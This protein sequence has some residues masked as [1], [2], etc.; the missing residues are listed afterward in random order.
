LLPD[1]FTKLDGTRITAKADWECRREEIRKMLEKVAY[2]TKPAAPT[3]VSGTVSNTMISVTATNG[4][5]TG[6]FSATVSLPTTGTAPYPA[7]IYIGGLGADTA[8]IQGEGVALITLDPNVVGAEGHGH[9]ANQTGAF[10]SI[11]S[12]GSATG[13]LA[14]WAWGVSRIIDV[15]EQS[16]GSIIQA[17]AIGVT[18]CS[19][20]GKAA[21]TAGA[22]DERIALTMPIESGTAGVPIWRGIAKAVVGANGNPSQSLSNAYNE[23]PWFADAFNAFTGDPTKAPVDTHEEVAMVA[24]R[25]LFIMDNPFIGELSPAF[26][27]VAALAGAE[28]YTAL[29]AGSNISYH[30][31][32]QSGTHCSIRPEWVTPLKNN[33]EK[34]LKKTG[35]AAGVMSPAAS[36]TGNLSQ[37]RAWTTPTLN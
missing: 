28:V 30:S 11:Y 18:G 16:N 33:I 27:D 10:Y 8:T 29:G 9:G 21:F 36:Q 7:V 1:P 13:L 2:G 34:Y 35:N 12:G 17:G 4:G 25:G 26:G 20:D 23:Q 3:T 19:R 22:F 37:W 14:A 31:S 6:T 32:V 15:I 24:P 5:K